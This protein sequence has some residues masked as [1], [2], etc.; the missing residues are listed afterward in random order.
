MDLF[1]EG[2]PYT[3][4][5]I[6]GLRTKAGGG[7]RLVL[8]YVSIGEAEDYRY[9]WQPGWSPGNPSWLEEENPDWPGNYGVR[10]WDPAWQ[11]VIFGGDDS[12]LGRVLAAGFDGAYLDRIDAF[13]DFE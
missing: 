9:Y 2:E 5:E 3:A 7:T 6:A 12:Y 10:Y 13:E 1:H 4:A 11:A 8:C